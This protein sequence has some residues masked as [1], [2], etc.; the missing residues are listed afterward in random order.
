MSQYF[1]KN[2]NIILQIGK[3]FGQLSQSVF[4]EE[5]YSIIDG[6]P[7]EINLSNEKN[8][9]LTILKLIND[10]LVSSVHDISSGGLLL[11]LAEMTFKSGYGIKIDKPKNLSNLME[12]YFSEDQ[13]RY[14]VEI[15][16]SNLE[17]V[18]KILKENN[19]FNEIVGTVQKDYFEVTGQLKINT[20]E[21]YKINNTWYNNF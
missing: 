3:N 21:L 1:K 10:K 16:P 2:E 9:G 12:Y 20:N 5:I 15:E 18:T 4:L 19:V 17:K 8:N 6:P 7:P 13:G 11:A 14:V